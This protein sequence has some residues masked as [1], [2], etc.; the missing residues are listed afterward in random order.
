MDAKTKPPFALPLARAKGGRIVSARG[1]VVAERLAQDEAT[2]ICRAVNAHADLVA[3]L[4]PLIGYMQA[5]GGDEAY[6][7]ADGT[8]WLTRARAALAKA[9]GDL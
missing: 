5:N 4:E 7:D 3:A 8:G 2:Y 6:H 1:G 9:K